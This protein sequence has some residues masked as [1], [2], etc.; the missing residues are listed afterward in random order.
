M[1]NDEG[2]NDLI[3]SPMFNWVTIGP[4]FAFVFL[5]RRVMKRDMST[6]PGSPSNMSNFATSF[7]SVLAWGLV[8]LV[9]DTFYGVDRVIGVCLGLVLVLLLLMTTNRRWNF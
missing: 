4:M 2:T 6:R 9:W 7:V 1:F 8:L 3:L 5:G